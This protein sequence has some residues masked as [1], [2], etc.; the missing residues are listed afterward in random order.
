MSQT[1]WAERYAEMDKRIGWK[2]QHL[3]DGEQ[4]GKR[5]KTAKS[6]EQ[7]E[8]EDSRATRK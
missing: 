4:I 5:R 7:R 8:S 3:P 6:D 1:D 2:Y